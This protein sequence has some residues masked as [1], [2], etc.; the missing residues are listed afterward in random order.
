VVLGGPGWCTFGRTAG[1]ATQPEWIHSQGVYFEPRAGGEVRILRFCPNKQTNKQ[2]NMF[3][4]CRGF[5]KRFRKVLPGP[6]MVVEHGRL[7]LPKSEH[8]GHPST[9]VNFSTTIAA[10]ISDQGRK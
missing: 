1:K 2:T 4:I 9:I 6:S 7:D 8:S 10:L 5:R 3:E